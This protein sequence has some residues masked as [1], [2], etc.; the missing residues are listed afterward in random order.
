MSTSL[1]PAIARRTWPALGTTCTVLTTETAALERAC[2]VV[3]NELGLVDATYSRF[4]PDSE[5]SRLN[6]AGR[7]TIVSPLLAEALEA[8]LRAARVSDG[9]VDPTVGRA[10]RAVGYEAD[11]GML[12]GRDVP[13]ILRIEALP[14]WRAIDYQGT[15]RR[16]TLPRGVELDLGSV[17]KALAAD[18]AVAAAHHAAGVGVLVSL[19]GDIATAGAGPV[20][21][22]PILVADDSAAPANGPGE[23]VRIMSGAIAT[24]STAVRRWTQDG[25]ERHHL[26]DPATGAPAVSP[27][28]TATVVA[29]SCVDANTVATAVIIKG[30][31][32][33]AW[34]ASV[35][36][37][38][39]LVA[40]DGRV[41]RINGWPEKAVVAA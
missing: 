26:I 39:R 5:L 30:A 17:G 18:R 27:W 37:P 22:W 23:V 8:A 3:A 24:S 21:G 34:L 10:M 25:I 32:A 29:C 19:G 35:G 12:A 6:R 36:L 15:T 14:G 40:G 2:A 33:P 20:P 28:R 4:R 38:T 16:V 13:L 41:L 7:P 31:Q 9:A 1:A 11:Y